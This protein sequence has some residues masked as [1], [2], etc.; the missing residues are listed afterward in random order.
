LKVSRDFCETVGPGTMAR[1]RH[2]D[3]STE[4]PDGIGD[5]LIVGRDHDGID[6]SRF[7]G[8]SIDMLDHRATAD[9]S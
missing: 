4:L 1:C 3:D 5:P 2:P 8:A 9:I 6:V 7:G